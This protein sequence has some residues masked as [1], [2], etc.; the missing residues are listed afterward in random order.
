MDFGP[1]RPY[2][3]GLLGHFEPK[4]ITHILGALWEVR[5]L[6]SAAAPRGCTEP[7]AGEGLR[8]DPEELLWRAL[9]PVKTCVSHGPMSI[10]ILYY[11]ILY[12][13]ILYYTILYS[14]LLYSTLLYSTLLY[15]TLLYYY[16]VWIPNKS[17]GG[18][19]ERHLCKSSSMWESDSQKLVM[20]SPQLPKWLIMQGKS[21]DMRWHH[22]TV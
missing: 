22:V 1:K 9:R 12:Y 21:L 16:T 3:I 5:A 17:G 14:T 13:V 18:N 7:G 19:P 10:L 20:P 15:S 8:E 2:Y 4:G 11:I 6:S